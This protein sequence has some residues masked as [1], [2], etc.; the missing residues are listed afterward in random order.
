MAESIGTVDFN[1]G[2]ET[3]KTWY[4]VVGDL[5]PG[6]TPLVV[7]HGGPGMSHHYMICHTEIYTTHAIPVIFYD[8]IGSGASTHLPHKPKEFWTVE[9]F[10]DELDNLLAELGIG[11]NFDLLGHSWGGMLAADYVSTRHPNGLRRLI[12]ANAPP[13]VALW[14]KSVLQYLSR[15]PQDFQDLV[16]KHEREGTT[17][18]KEYQDVLEVFHNK[19][20]CQVIP[21]PEELVISF[22]AMEEDPTVHTMM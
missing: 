5:K 10:M 7:L 19:H 15:F 6:V 11:S 1:V 18:S 22:K 4:K 17:S 16:R 12:I 20:T 14:E 8:Q 21:W 13:S 3:Y 9:L 2:D